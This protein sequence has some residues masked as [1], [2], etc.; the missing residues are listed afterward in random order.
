M[1][2]LYE[3]FVVNRRKR[4]AL[5]KTAKINK[6]ESES[7]LN[8]FIYKKPRCLANFEIENCPSDLINKWLQGPEFLSKLIK[9]KCGE[10]KL[11][12]YASS[13]D[14]MLL[15]PI[16]LE[17]PKCFK[18]HLIF[19]PEMHGWDGENGDNAS[20]IG[21]NEPHKIN[22]LPREVIVDYSFQNPENYS[23][24]MDDG[25]KNP[26]DYFDVFIVNTINETGKLEEVVSYECA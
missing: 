4:S 25:I 6:K 23:E 8:N 16:D 13:N 14:E 15:A 11:F 19:N 9:C 12:V 1:Y 20:L 24:L 2:A 7:I 17:C 10:S 26:E 18:K 5:N 21:K 3:V 22:D